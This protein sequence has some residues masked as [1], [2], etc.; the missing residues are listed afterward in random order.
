[1]N[2]QHI[3]LLGMPVTN[4]QV[5]LEFYTNML[6]FA[7]RTNMEHFESENPNVRWIE[8]VPPGASTAIVLA[9]WETPGNLGT[10]VLV[11]TDIQAD[12]AELKAKGLDMPPLEHQPWGTSIMITDPDGNKLLLQQNHDM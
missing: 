8:L 7:I 10:I 5:S 1:M 6:G 2:I 11:T 12:Y 4:Q 9:P 3:D